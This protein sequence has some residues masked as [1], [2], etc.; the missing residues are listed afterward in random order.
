MKVF[1]FFFQEE[2]WNKSVKYTRLI[3]DPGSIFYIHS[4]LIQQ[5]FIECLHQERGTGEAIF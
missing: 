2:Q 3:H 4:K 1:F 5:I